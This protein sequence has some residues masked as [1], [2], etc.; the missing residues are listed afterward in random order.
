MID[1]GV[2][3][4]AAAAYLSDEA[5]QDLFAARG[6]VD[7]GVELHAENRGL[8]ASPMAA[9]G[10]FVLDARRRKPGGR[11]SMRSPCDIHTGWLPSGI[12]GLAPA[13]SITAGPYSRSCEGATRPPSA[14][15]SSCIP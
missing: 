6:M 15:V 9:K 13:V 4:A 2:Q 12:S 1:S 5:A 10:L 11:A 7:F 8:A 3:S 14:W